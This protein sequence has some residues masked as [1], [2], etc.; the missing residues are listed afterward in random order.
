ML[1]VIGALF[2]GGAFFL[3]AEAATLPARQRRELLKRAA[4]YGSRPAPNVVDREHSTFGERVLSPVIRAASR[5]V[6]RLTPRTTRDT[7]RQR[8]LSAGLAQ[9][10]TPDQFLAAKGLLGAFGGLFGLLAGSAL[11]GATGFVLALGAGAV[12]FLAPDFFV[13]GRVNGRR[14]AVQAAL[15]DALDLLAVSVEAGLGF[16]GAVAKLT[17]YMGGPLVEEFALTLNEMRIGETRTE[18]LKRM[19]ARVDCAEL[20]S[21]VRAVVQ[22]DQLGMSMGHMLRV[23]AAD[24]RIRRQLAAEEKAMKAPIKMLFPTAIFILPVMFVV[25][26]APAFMNYGKVF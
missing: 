7:V 15:P 23:Q 13:N 4:S 5:F 24:A 21:F 6:L 12:G 26:L 16:D 9:T 11:G 18:A 8:L 19:A 1:L 14:E 2:L 25:I 22:A 10:F 20:S 3:V 17:E